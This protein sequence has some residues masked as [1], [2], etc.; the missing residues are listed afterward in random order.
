VDSGERKVGRG[1]GRLKV[2]GDG[3]GKVGKA[4]KEGL[5]TTI[6]DDEK[7][8]EDDDDEDEDGDDDGDDCIRR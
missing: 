3:W 4:G 1:R 8:D 6:D 2:E 5:I 7:D